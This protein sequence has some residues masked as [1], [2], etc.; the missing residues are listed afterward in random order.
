[1]VK[2]LV[3]IHAAAVAITASLLRSQIDIVEDRGIGEDAS[4][5]QRIQR[6][7]DELALGAAPTNDQRYAVRRKAETDCLGK[8][9]DRRQVDYDYSELLL[10]AIDQL[11]KSLEILARPGGFDRGA[12]HKVRTRSLFDGDNVV[13][14]ALASEKI[15]QGKTRAMVDEPRDAG[16][17]QICIDENDP[18]A[19]QCSRSRKGERMGGLPLTGDR[20]GFVED[21][22]WPLRA[23]RSPP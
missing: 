12:R 9:E 15:S 6:E 2:S 19:R 7:L 3:G 8:A 10:Q 22:A 21:S 1:L 13:R 11:D 17:T 5:V 16:S 14:R 4:A 18:I 20:G 23:E